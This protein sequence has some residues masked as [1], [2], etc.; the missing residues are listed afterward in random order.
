MHVKS[1][2]SIIFLCVTW[3]VTAIANPVSYA[4]TG[5]MM[6][7]GDL[8]LVGNNEDYKIPYTRVWFVPAEKEKYG[9]IYFGYDNWTPQGGMNDQGLFF[10]Y[11]ATRKQESGLSKDKPKFPGPMIDTMMAKYASVEEVLEMFSQYNLEW[12]SK[13]QMF[14]VDKSGDSA[15]VEGETVVRNCDAYQVVTN[16]RL[17]KVPE[18]QRPCK[19][20]AYGCSRYKKAEN[21]LLEID[22]PS[23]AHFRDVLKATHRSTNNVIATTLYS[24][25]YD[26][27]NGLVYLYYLHDFENEI[28]FN[29]DQ[30][31]KKGRH[32]FDLPSLFGSELKYPVS[33]YT[34]T[35]PAFSISYPKRYEPVKPA[36]KE[37]LLVKNPMSTTP[38]MGVYVES[39]PENI[40]LKEIGTRYLL[41]VIEKYST[42][43]ELVYSTQTVLG[44][45]T[46]AMETLFNRVI[47][48]HWPF[49]TLVLS[50]YREDKLIYAATTSYAHPEALK[51]YL[52]SLRFH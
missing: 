46:P 17:S 14:I 40:L 23:V 1:N 18:S 7:D 5:F 11:F 28:V 43:A 22:I 21:L 31:L 27:T 37:V 12:M 39:Q 52:Y 26:L 30:E 36:L 2:V 38:Q 24:N 9:R 29:L 47:Q 3:L 13:A 33:V 19:W 41:G 25:I 34:H 49:Q 42:R 4:C 10:D 6:T 16:F 51:E 8:V 32:Y 35:T 20:P 44:D 50:T 15:I 45:G 48:D